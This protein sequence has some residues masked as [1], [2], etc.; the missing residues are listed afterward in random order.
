MKTVKTHTITT[1]RIQLDVLTLQFSKRVSV[2]HNTR[3]GPS[4]RLSRAESQSRDFGNIIFISCGSWC[5]LCLAP[6]EENQQLNY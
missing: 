2:N 5:T 1:Y 6:S 3:D 4:G